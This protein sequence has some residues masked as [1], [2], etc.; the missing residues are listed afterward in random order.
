MSDSFFRKNIYFTLLLGV[1]FVAFACSGK[2]ES[3]SAT[4]NQEASSGHAQV[5][6][7]TVPFY[8]DSN[9]FEIQIAWA[10]SIKP[11]QKEH[12][13]NLLSSMVRVEGGSFTM[14]CTQSKDKECNETEFPPHNVILS[15]F[16]ISKY[17]T[18]QALWVEIMGN[19]PNFRNNPNYPIT[20]ISW[21]DT[22]KFIEQL[23]YL[24]GLNFALP[25]QAEWEYAARGGRKSHHTIYAGSD[26][27]DDVAVYIQ[28][29]DS[30]FSIRGR[31]QANELGLYDMS[32]N[33][34]E[35]CSDYYAP[36]TAEDQ[37][38]P[39]GPTSG[40]FRVYRGGSWIDSPKYNRV[41]TRNSGDPN[42]KMNCIGFRLVLK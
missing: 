3:Q 35:W 20:N 7:D 27:I 18:L 25:T 14:G 32:G 11:S 1:I 40:E 2:K 9:Q 8:I 33:V 42:H 41:T 34:W 6:R 23:N 26:V 28:T 13:E 36:Y 16:F 5:P 19:N 39:Q 17:E 37:I 24:T 30:K 12:I 31:K 10:K 15:S 22:Q 21:N 29:S 38:D 4:P